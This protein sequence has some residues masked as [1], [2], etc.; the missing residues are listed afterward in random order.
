MFFD[1]VF[2]AH[3]EKSMKIADSII[4]DKINIFWNIRTRVDMVDR[5][6]LEIYKKAGCHKIQYGIESG[7]DRILENINKG[8][9]LKQAI[10]AIE[11]TK[12]AG[13]DVS[14][15]FMLGL[16]GETRTEI[17]KTLK[18]ALSYPLDY[19]IF[20]L[21]TPVPF[22]DLYEMGLKNGYFYD[23]W[24][25]YAR[26]PKSEKIY[27]LWEEYFTKDE[28]IEMMK[29]CYRKYYFR[30]N[31]VK[32]NILKIKSWNEFKNK[33]WAGMMLFKEVIKSYFKKSILN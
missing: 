31:Y 1:E 9:K 19:V 3:R 30:V 8:F 28:L 15:T 14:A 17:M 26:A 22:T 13:I 10:K 5:E 33:I 16:P 12:E 2:S 27:P 7:D 21:A 11:M 4:N 6:M 25:E 20:S 32:R 18:F 24:K 23:V 29:Y